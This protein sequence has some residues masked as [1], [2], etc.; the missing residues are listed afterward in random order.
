VISVQDVGLRQADDPDVLAWAAVQGRIVVTHDVS[1]MTD[2]AYERILTGQPMP[3]VIAIP[4]T[5]PRATIIDELIL[6]AHATT[7]Q[8]WD[9]AVR[10]LPLR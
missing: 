1:T 4:A 8:E 3:G 2:H 5:V 9:N 10:Y 6:I 7:A